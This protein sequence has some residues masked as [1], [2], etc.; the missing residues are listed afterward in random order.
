MSAASSPTH[1]LGRDLAQIVLSSRPISWINT[2]FPFAAAYLLSTRE[3]DITLVIGTLYFLIPYNLAMYGIN[4]VFD[5]ASDLAN[6]R[7]GG[8]EGALLAPR[9]HRA[10]LWAAAA[11]N[12]PF[13]V[14]LVIVGNPASWFWLAVSVFA[15]IAYSAPVL[16]FKERPFLDSVT[17]STHFVSPAIVGLALVGAPVTTGTVL[18][19]G[20]FFLWGMAAHA[21]GAVQDIGPDREAGISSIATVIGA[22]TTVRL[23]LS[24]WAIAGAAMLLTPW[25]GPLAAALAVPYLVNAAPWWNVT[26]ENSASTNRAWRRFIA[27][28][29]FAGFLATMILILAWTS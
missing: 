3:I 10:T 13:L 12:V 11:T 22:R 17:S 27:L 21:F 18:T 2:A 15:V 25:P 9:I 23:S 16:R 7:K 19:L 28:N 26:D 6:P 20:A 8:I 1:S 29:Y 24:L 4:D 5:Y 14:Y